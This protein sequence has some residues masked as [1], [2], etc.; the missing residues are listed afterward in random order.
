MKHFKEIEIPQ[1]PSLLETLNNLLTLK[2]LHWPNCNQI[3]L[4]TKLGE[5]DNYELGAG[6]LI[7]DWDNNYYTEV[8]SITSVNISKKT[9]MLLETDFTIL[10]NQFKNTDFEILYN[11]LNSRYVLG[12]VRLMNLKPKKCL[13]WHSDDSLRLHYP[14]YTQEGCF[15]IIEDEVMH[16]PLGTWTMTDTTKKHTAFNGSKESRIHLVAVILGNR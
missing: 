2:V 8:N 7:L 6:S 1:F 10:C 3:C 16:L 12:R 14:L 4:N 15:M 9:D 5:E 13:S 11:E